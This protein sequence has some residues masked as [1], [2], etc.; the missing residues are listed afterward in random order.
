MKAL[1]FAGPDGTRGPA[2]SLLGVVKRYDGV[3]AVDSL[4]L[5][6]RVGECFGLLGPNG[7]GKTTTIEILIGLQEP[8]SGQV[9]VLG[10]KWGGDDRSLR[11]RIGVSL[12]ETRFPERLTVAEVVTLFRSFYPRGR[13]V[14]SVIREVGLEEKARSWTSKLSGGQRQRLALACALVGD[15]ELLVLDEPTTGLDPQARLQFGDSIL[16]YKDRGCTI[17]VSTHYMEEAQRLCDRVAIIERGKAIAI[18]SPDELIA[19]LDGNLVVEIEMAAGDVEDAAV[20]RLAGVTSVRRE[21]GAL[22][23][24]VQE[25]HVTVPALLDLFRARSAS[26]AHLTL[27]QATLEDVYVSLTG[28]QYRDE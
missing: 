13:D 25:A 14:P 3:V 21:N 20:R 28:R 11:A 12:Q 7:A 4:D 19:S 22:L 1:P 24:S 15:P 23:V 26:L 10:T 16:S 18:G 9:V 6:I 17:L 2:V 8:T 5:E 27:R